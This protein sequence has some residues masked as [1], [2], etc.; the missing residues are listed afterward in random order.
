MNGDKN[1]VIESYIHMVME[2]N[3]NNLPKSK[4]IVGDY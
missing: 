1:K 4:L 2:N 3:E